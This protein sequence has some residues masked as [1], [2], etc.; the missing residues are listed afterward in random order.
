MPSSMKAPPGD[1]RGIGEPAR[2]ARSKPVLGN[3]PA[4]RGMQQREVAD[5]AAIDT[6][7]EAGR[8]QTHLALKRHADDAGRLDWRRPCDRPRPSVIA[9]G[10]PTSTCL[11]ACGGA[12]RQPRHVRDRRRNLHDVHIVPR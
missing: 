9:M 7:L 12:N 4:R 1:V 6:S 10:L 8:A 3:R 2:P 11:P 5:V